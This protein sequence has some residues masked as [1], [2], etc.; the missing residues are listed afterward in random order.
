MKTEDI[1]I[2]QYTL[3]EL[4]GAEREAFEK[5]MAADPGLL[6]EVRLTQQFCES[7]P[8]NPESAAAF[9]EAERQA[10]MAK[11]TEARAE[12]GGRK[13][14]PRVFLYGGLAATA[15]CVVASLSIPSVTGALTRRGP[16]MAKIETREREFNSLSVAQAAATPASLPAETSGLVAANERMLQAPL[17]ESKNSA[18]SPAML[19]KSE[20]AQMLAAAPSAGQPQA[21]ADERQVLQEALPYLATA[22]PAVTV[23]RKSLDGNMFTVTESAG[24]APLA[25]IQTLSVS[26]SGVAGFAG[27]AKDRLARVEFDHSRAKKAEAFNTE[28]YD[29]LEENRFLSA[30]ENPLSTFSIDVDTAS[31]SN[32]RRFL[33]QQGQLPPKG[34]VRI[35]ELVNY[36]PYSYPQP[37]GTDPF[38][39]NVEVGKAPWNPRHDLVRIALKGREIAAGKRPASNLV[40]LVDVSGSMDEPDKLPLLQRSL[41]ELTLRLAPKDRVAIVVYAGSSGL[42]L[43]STADKAAIRDAL[44]RLQAGGSTNGGEGIKLAYREARANF[45]EDGNNRVILCTDGDFNVGVTSEQ[46][47]VDLIEK[48]RASGVFLSVLG[49]GTGNLKDSQMEKLADRGNGN[50]AY[51]DSPAEGRKV[52]GEQM[53][54]TLFTI[55]KDVKIQVE[56]NPAAVEGYRLIGYENR[57]LAKE[58]FND[59]KKDAGEIGSGHTVTAF[60]EVVPAGQPLPDAASVDELK[61]QPV[62][63]KNPQSAIRNPQSNEL[64]TVKLRYKQPDGGTSQLL[65]APVANQAKEWNA[66]SEDFRFGAAVAAFGLKLRHSKTVKAVDWAQIQKLARTSLGE[67]PG[68]YRAEFLTLI[69]KARQIDENP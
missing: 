7:L 49:F 2:T 34:A 56:F 46:A 44:E 6:E 50:Y 26:G 10:L 65:Q 12:R 38:S 62:D 58:D 45:L 32:V 14:W 39:V 31:Y 42:V 68:S 18:D 48:E 25:E 64:L 51:I 19:E 16:E 47:L 35:E 53:G 40:F 17:E 55:A 41:V 22:A 23:N 1:R 63:S 69:E 5:E 29:Y 20:Q 43:P 13:V 61:Y 4:A 11:W 37:E 8:P 15:A 36:F 3:G 24:A 54:A 33:Q 21:P 28:G 52:L 67:D 59:D 60:Y 9:S 27:K 57:L 66:C 30:R